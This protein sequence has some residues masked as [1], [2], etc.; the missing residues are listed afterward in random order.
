MET[1]DWF[2]SWFDTPY[3]HI[4]YKHRNDVEAELFMQNVTR[5]LKLPKTAH[6]LDLPCGKGRY[7]IYLNTLGY[8]VTG[9]DLSKNSIALA[10]RYENERLQFEVAD[11][12]DEIKGSYDAIF[13]LFTSFGYFDNDEDDL[14]VLRAIK[15]G[16]KKDGVFVLDFLNVIKAKNDLIPKEEKI[17][18]GIAFQIQKSIENG[19]IKKQISFFADGLT[20]H[21]TEN[22][23]LLDLNKMKNYLKA[24]DFEILEVFGDYDLN[25]FDEATS[26]RLILILK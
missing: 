19:F 3:Y 21:Y 4:L 9:I 11:M 10:K 2:T 8:K 14:K 6:I 22:V 26:N 25:P 7:S 15:S 16:L 12:R 5:F 1:K 24:V 13:N 18:D 20:H 23:K 17:I